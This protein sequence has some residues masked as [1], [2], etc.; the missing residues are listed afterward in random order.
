MTGWVEIP[1]TNLLRASS[2]YEALIGRPLKH[3]VLF[4]I[5]HALFTSTGGAFGAIVEDPSKA[6]SEEDN[7]VYFSAATEKE[8]D[9]LL[10]RAASAGGEVLLPK[11]EL[12]HQGLMA[13]VRDSEGNRIGIHMR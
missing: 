4:G 11:T 6:P 3:H 9:M 7:L 10:V 12:G 5:P 13:I 8:L 2:F 1:C